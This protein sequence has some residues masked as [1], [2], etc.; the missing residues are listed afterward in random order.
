MFRGAAFRGGAHSRPQLAALGSSSARGVMHQAAHTMRALSLSQGPYLADRQ[1]STVREDY[2]SDGSAWEHFPHAEARSRVYRW[3]EDGA[4]AS[5]NT[6]D[7][8]I[9]LA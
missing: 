1:W 9:S 7:F 8:V 3:G 5:A 6:R 4:T 2:S